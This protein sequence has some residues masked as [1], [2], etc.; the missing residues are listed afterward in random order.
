MREAIAAKHYRDD[1]RNKEQV[2]DELSTEIA[3]ELHTPWLPV[4]RETRVG[5]EE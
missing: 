1:L 2:A 4:E 5:T 3:E